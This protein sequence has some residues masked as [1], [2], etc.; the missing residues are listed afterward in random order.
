MI[1]VAS[2]NVSYLSHTQEPYQAISYVAEGKVRDAFMDRHP[3]PHD[4]TV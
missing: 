1:Q 4:R 2:K 3:S